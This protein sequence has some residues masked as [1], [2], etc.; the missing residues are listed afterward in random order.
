MIYRTGN[1]YY[2][3]VIN[4]PVLVY[5][6]RIQIKTK[7]TRFQPYVFMFTEMYHI[8]LFMEYTHTNNEQYVLCV[9]LILVL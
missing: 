8:V 9:P 1:V 6:I 4:A 5:L 7:Q 2:A 3:V